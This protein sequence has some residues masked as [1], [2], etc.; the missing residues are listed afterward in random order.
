M[1]EAAEQVF[2]DRGFDGANMREIASTAGVNKYMLYYH[3]ED[4]QTLFEQVLNA[5]LTPVFR[6]LSDAIEPAPDLETAIGNVYQIYADLFAA[7]G[8]RLRSFMGRELAAGAPRAQLLFKVKAPE[9][10]SIWGIKLSEYAGEEIPLETVAKTVMSI[11][12]SIVSTFLMAPL[13]EPMLGQFEID[14]AKADFKQH[15]V[16]FALG[17][18]DKC[19]INL[20]TK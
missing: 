14:M 15:V 9:L 4:K 16:D 5:I 1:L 8:G 7:R 3:F 10:A 13:F 18:V 2:A 17:G 19:L 12:T 6:K 11:M 20:S